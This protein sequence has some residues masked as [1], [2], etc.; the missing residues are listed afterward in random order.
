VVRAVLR[1]D[2]RP[3]T[4]TRETVR[5]WGISS[6]WESGVGSAAPGADLRVGGGVG[7]LGIALNCL[8]VRVAESTANCLQGHPGVDQFGGVYMPQLV[9]CGGDLRFRR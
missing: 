6:T 7:L 5:I 8:G 9:D 3:S 1:R 2:K 4:A